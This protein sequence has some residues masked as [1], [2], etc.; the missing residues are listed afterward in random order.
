[1]K[2]VASTCP[3]QFPDSAILFE[4]SESGL[5]AGLLASPC[6]VQVIQGTAY[7]P[8]VNV[9]TTDV[10]LPPRTGL[11]APSSAQVVTLTNGGY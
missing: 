10:L 9:G 3:E 4:P 1:M 11:G 6:L 7:I 5:P 2:L 8:V